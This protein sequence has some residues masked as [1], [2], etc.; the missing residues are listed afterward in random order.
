MGLIITPRLWRPSDALG[1]QCVAE[2]PS[3]VATAVGL[4]GGGIKLNFIEKIQLMKRLGIH[5]VAG[6]VS[7][8][9]RIKLVLPHT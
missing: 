4:Q 8:A 2:V 5:D 6:L 3:V 7:Y 9:V 1:R